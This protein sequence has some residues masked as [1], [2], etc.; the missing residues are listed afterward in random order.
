VLL[1]IY[2]LL[3]ICITLSSVYLV[4]DSLLEWRKESLWDPLRKRRSLAKACRRLWRHVVR[5]LRV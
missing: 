2:V 3:G 5:K 1:V 4:L